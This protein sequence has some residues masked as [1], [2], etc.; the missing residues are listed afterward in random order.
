MH[1]D[2]SAGPCPHCGGD[3]DGKR[4][5]AVS[6]RG[7]K[8]AFSSVMVA[9]TSMRSKKSLIFKSFGHLVSGIPMDHRLRLCQ[10]SVAERPIALPP[11][12]R[13]GERHAPVKRRFISPTDHHPICGSCGIPMWLTKIELEITTAG[14][15]RHT[16]ACKACGQIVEITTR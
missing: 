8:P 15:E 11:V 14:N 13:D 4:A 7:Q 9:V 6:K 3:M 2:L 10:A 1:T 16:F 12:T 5:L